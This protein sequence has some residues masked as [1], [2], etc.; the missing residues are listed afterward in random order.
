M[1]RARSD[2]ISLSD[3]PWYHILSRC[4]RRAFLCGE[5][6]VTGQNYDH[7][8]G[9]IEAKI[10]QLASIFTIDIAAY[11][12][13]SNHYH[14]VVRIDAERG[15]ALSDEDVLA[16]WL[17]LFTGPKLIQ[18]YQNPDE[19]KAMSQAERDTVREYIDL[20][21]TRL[22]D[23]SWFMRVLNESIARMANK[24]DGVKG[25]FWEGRFKS[26]ALLD[27][28]AI[29]A[30]MAYVDLNPIRAAMAETPE[31]SDY[32]SLQARIQPE[33][34]NHRIAKAIQ[35]MEQNQQA[36]GEA[37]AGC[38]PVAALASDTI[39]SN[40]ESVEP[41]PLMP[42]DATARHAWAIPFALED[43]LELVD[44]LGRHV[45]PAKR[46]HIPEHVP[47]LLQRLNLDGDTFIRLS[48]VLLRQFGTVIGMPENMLA[49]ATRRQVKFLHGIK[50]ARSLAQDKAA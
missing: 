25:R 18:R 46:G 49:F 47:K 7:R 40:P 13:M 11:A 22:Y 37:D 10:R 48:T 16:R 36:A 6:H 21:R 19:R 12:I 8:R 43:Y 29:L 15:Q 2:L 41:A 14:I 30:A 28:Q 34:V 38:V 31:Q 20:Y 1:T 50:A 5:D 27:E 45:H 35:S 26:Q 3:T 23:L 39:K 4:V 33:K 32:T 24:E 42:F 17:M 44:T 9:W